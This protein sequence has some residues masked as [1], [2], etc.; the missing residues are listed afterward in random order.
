M[1]DWDAVEKIFQAATLRTNLTIRRLSNHAI[2]VAHCGRQSRGS[3]VVH[4]Q[5]AQ[6][7]A[8]LLP[9]E[10]LLPSLQTVSSRLVPSPA[11]AHPV[12]GLVIPIFAS[13]VP[14]SPASNRSSHTRANGLRPCASIGGALGTS[15]YDKNR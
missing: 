2:S 9:L 5:R 10:G 3:P 12:V 11:A 13:H 6:F 15:Q 14:H 7:L 4:E 8:V 1:H